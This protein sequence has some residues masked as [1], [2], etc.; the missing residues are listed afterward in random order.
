MKLLKT[1]PLLRA[2]TSTSLLEEA[3]KP[4]AWL[5]CILTTLFIPAA[6]LTFPLVAQADPNLGRAESIITEIDLGESHFRLITDRPAIPTDGSYSYVVEITPGEGLLSVGLHFQLMREEDGWPFHYF[7]DSVYIERS[8]QTDDESDDETEDGPRNQRPAPPAEP[9]VIRRLLERR[10]ANNLYGLGMYEGVYYVAVIVTAVTTAGEESATLRDMLVVYNPNEPQLNLMPTIHLSALPSRN[11]QGVFLSH[12]A[13]GLFD[14]RREML[15]AISGWINDTQR[16]RLT[17]AISPL[18]LEELAIMAEGF[19]YLDIHSEEII[20]LDAESEEAQVAAQTLENLRTAHGT[21]RLSITA[22]GYA[23][24]DFSVLDA[25][26]LVDDLPSHFEIGQSVLTSTFEQEPPSITV[27]WTSQLTA[28]QFQTLSDVLPQTTPRNHESKIILD[29]DTLGFAQTTINGTDGQRFNQNLY[30]DEAG[31]LLIVADSERSAALSQIG[32]RAQIILDL[33][34]ERQRDG[35]TPLLIQAQDDV[36]SIVVLLDNLELLSD[37]NWVNLVD[38]NF[39]DST[40]AS[41]LN[42]VAAQ[43]VEDIPESVQ[44]L[45]RSRNEVLGLISALGEV[46]SEQQEMLDRYYLLSLAIFA[47]LGTTIGEYTNGRNTDNDNDSLNIS[48]AAY[49]CLDL[50]RQLSSYADLWFSGIEIHTQAH[51][52]SGNSGVLPITILNGSDQTLYLDVRYIT[53]G[54]NVVVYPEYIQQAFLSGES[55][56][57]PTVELRNIV[58]GSVDVQIWAGNHLIATESVRVSATYTDRIVIIVMVA[59]AGTGLAFFIWKR[60]RL[61]EENGKQVKESARA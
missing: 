53:T 28:E 36:D 52:F 10:T 7:G 35:I 47:G 42:F 27:P 33:L 26:D 24:P 44:E 38:S 1:S 11:T 6:L 37:Y 48:P 61:S 51:T 18:F 39:V 55:F 43:E 13:G 5:L 14:E 49:E 41:S 31:D 15:D 8:V 19:D 16:A 23:D 45:Q 20:T 9:E 46:D 3:S 60:V 56:L 58:S 54:Q 34:E 57:E 32:S 30:Q 21:G 29:S 50:A 4:T 17:L 22:Q 12:P 59:L 25:L 40:Q 2:N